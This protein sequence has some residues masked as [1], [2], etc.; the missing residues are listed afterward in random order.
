MKHTFFIFFCILSV[1]IGQAQVSGS[2]IVKGDINTYYPVVF[3]DGG[4]ANNKATE[5]FIGRSAV[6]QDGSWRGSMITKFRYHCNNWGN[7]SN[8]IDADIHQFNTADHSVDISDFVGGWQDASLANSSSQIII[9]LRGGTTTYYY[10]ATYA[11][12]PV[13]YDGVQNALPFT[14]ANM[15]SVTSKTTQDYYVNGNGTSN[16]GTARIGAT[17]YLSEGNGTLHLGSNAAMNFG[18]W[19]IPNPAAKSALVEVRNTGV[20]DMFGT[21]TNGATNFIRMFTLDAV[22]NKVYF[23]SG[24]VLIGKSSQTNNSYMLDVGGNVRA[25]KVVVN[26]TGADFVFEPSYKLPSLSFVED[27]VKKYRHLPGIATAKDMQDKGLDVGEH[28]TNLLQKIEELTLYTIEQDKKI[29]T[30]DKKIVSQSEEL[31]GLKAQV[32]VQAEQLK[33]LLALVKPAK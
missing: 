27:Y 24:N 26:T 20:I 32:K 28:Q 3:F 12:T 22:A 9:W 16:T 6:H 2:F 1:S 14:P 7:G 23:P 18:V 29:N 13:V 33:L 11:V 30:Q 19:E 21:N 25:N 8:F 4:Y 10:N 5:L 31:E 17:G 15:A